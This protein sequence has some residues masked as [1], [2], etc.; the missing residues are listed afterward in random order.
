MTTDPDTNPTEPDQPTP[1]APPQDPDSP[2]PTDNPPP[3]VQTE[4]PTA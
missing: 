4:E 3:D 2:T 1:D